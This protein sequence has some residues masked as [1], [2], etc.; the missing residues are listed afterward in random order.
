MTKQL[1]SEKV[2]LASGLHGQKETLI[3]LVS[4]EL[5]K[6]VVPYDRIPERMSDREH[7][8][9]LL[10]TVKKEVPAAIARELIRISNG[11]DTNLQALAL[12][13]ASVLTYKYVGADYFLLGVPASVIPVQ[14]SSN[15]SFK[16]LLLVTRKRL[17]EAQAYLQYPLEVLADELS[18]A[19]E[20][21]DNPFFDIAVMVASS[22]D[23]LWMNDIGTAFTFSLDIEV[24]L[25]QLTLYY[26]AE[27]YNQSSAERLLTHFLLILGKSL[28]DPEQPIGSISIMRD[29][30]I[31]QLQQELT[32]ELI[33]EGDVLLHEMFARK[34][35]DIPDHTAL[36][37]GECKLSYGELKKRADCIGRELLM[38]GAGIGT[39]AAIR[40]ERSFDMVAGILAILSIGGTYLPIEP[41][42]PEARYHYILEDSSASILL[43]SQNLEN[44]NHPLVKT[45][46]FVENITENSQ[47]DADDGEPDIRPIKQTL[48]N[49]AYI[50]YTS[51]TTGNPKGTVIQHKQI[52]CLLR[53][54]LPMFE[55]NSDDRWTLFHSFSFDFSVWEMFGALVTG[56]TLVI[57]A[58]HTAKDTTSFA[59][60]LIEEAVTV[61][62]QTPSAF[63]QLIR[64][65]SI[66]AWDPRYIIFGGEALMPSKIK[67]WAQQHVSVQ[68][69]NMYG[70][71]ETTIHATFKRLEEKD[72]RSSLSNIGVLLPHLQG[73]IVDRDGHPVPSGV[74]GEL[75][76]AGQGVAQG[77]HR[78]EKLTQ[79]RFM[80]HPL[81]ETTRFYRTGDLVRRMENGDLEYLGRMDQQVKIRGYRIEIGEIME[82]LLLHDSVIDAAITTEIDD[83]GRTEL[84]AYIIA[85]NVITNEEIRSF[86]EA[87]LPIYMVP[88]H[89]YETNS[90]P[91][92]INGKLDY[93]KLQSERK[94]LAARTTKIS[95]RN[96]MEQVIFD[97][98]KKHVPQK[99][100]F[101]VDDSLFYIG[102]HSLIASLII[103]EVNQYY[104]CTLSIRS[105]FEHPT[106][107]S[108][109]EEIKERMDHT[110]TNIPEIGNK[111]HYECSS[112]QER[113]YFLSQAAGEESTLYN[114]P[115]MLE[116]KG[117]LEEEK[118]QS[119][120]K[121]LVSR[122]AVLRTCLEVREG[123]PVMRIV[124]DHEFT[125]NT[126]FA[127]TSLDEMSLGGFIKSFVRPFK[128]NNV[129]LYRVELL[130]IAELHY[131][132][133][134]DMHHIIGDGTTLEILLSDLLS[135]YE[136]K[137]LDPISVGYKD[138]A[139]WQ[140]RGLGNKEMLTHEAYWLEQFGGDIPIL[141]LP[142]DSPKK[143]TDDW[144]GS[145]LK[146]TCDPDIVPAITAFAQNKQTTLFTV[147][148]AAF[149]V[150][151]HKYSGQN[152]IVVG[153]PVEGREHPDVK[154]VAGVFVNT[155]ALRN[156][157]S[158]QMTFDQ[159]L[160]EV[161][162]TLISALEHQSYPFEKLVSET[163]T[164]RGIN[165]NPLFDT[166][167]S[168]Q[169]SPDIPKIGPLHI[170]AKA[171]SPNLAKFDL[172]L[173]AVMHNERSLD[174]VWE[175]R[176]N[177]FREE[178]I[179]RLSE[180]FIQLLRLITDDPSVPL[181]EIS[182]MSDAERTKLL[183]KWNNT[184]SAYHASGG[185][186]QWFEKWSN[187][188]GEHTALVTSEERL[189]YDEL[190]K[191]S[192]HMAHLLRSYGVNRNTLVG[193][194]IRRN[195]NLLIAIMAVLKAG[196]AYLPIDPSFPGERIQHMLKNSGAK[197]VLT[198]LSK[199]DHITSAW[200]YDGEILRLQDE[201]AKQPASFANPQSVNDPDDMAYILYTSGST[202]SP[203]GVVITHD[204]LF[205]FIHA[206]GERLDCPA[207][208]GVLALTTVSFD[209]F[210]VEML[211]P[212]FNGM[213]VLL[214]DEAMQQDPEWLGKFVQNTPVHTL[215]LTP[216]RLGML[217]KHEAG[218]QLLSQSKQILVGG[219]HLSLVL[220]AELQAVTQA[221]I[222]NMYGPTETT[223]WST[224]QELTLSTRNDIGKPVANTQ[225]YVL[226]SLGKPVPT[227]V[228]GE[229]Y[230][231]GRGVSRG[232]HRNA[233]L[234]EE[235]FVPNIF[236]G[237]G[238]MYKT[239]DLVRWLEN[240]NL[241]YMGRLDHQVKIRGYRIDTEEVQE[242]IM[243]Y[244]GVA[245]A[246]VLTEPSQEHGEILVGYYTARDFCAPRE[247]RKHLSKF[248]PPYMVPGRLIHVSSFPL[249]PN[250]KLDRKRLST[251][252][253]IEYREEEA[254]QLVKPS[255]ELEQQIASIWEKVLGLSAPPSISQSFFEI[256]GNS[257]QASSILLI[258]NDRLGTNISLREFFIEPTVRALSAL[259]ET[260]GLAKVLTIPVTEGTEYYPLSPA[261]RRM[262]FLYQLE[263]E[264]QGVSYN[265]PLMVRVRGSLDPV[266][267][268]LALEKLVARHSSLRTYF[269]ILDGKPVQKIQPTAEIPVCYR[270]IQSDKELPE[271]AAQFIQPFTLEQAPLAR[272]CL[273]RIGQN[274]SQFMMDMH[275]IVADGISTDIIIR[276][277]LA[278]YEEKQLV[279]APRVDYKDYSVWQIH[280]IEAGAYQDAESFWLKLLDGEL[281]LL[282]LPIDRTR[283][284]VKGYD[285]DTIRTSL[286]PSLREK[287][288]QVAANK[289]VTLNTLLLTAYYTL[290]HRLT[291]QE[292]VIVG[293]PFANRQQ[294]DVQEMI[295]MFVNTVALRSYPS[296]EKTI[297]EYAG[298][299]S[300]LLLAAQEQQMI[301]FENLIERLN[302]PRDMSRNPLFDTMFSY[303]N[304]QQQLPVATELELEPY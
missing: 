171:I 17:N 254:H 270:E 46:I 51:G 244:E 25:V 77:Y 19:W 194:V 207:G 290:L 2:L 115:A 215:Q 29:E 99:A 216:S 223:I 136:E 278:L 284:A 9:T 228:P 127:I 188:L 237:D 85:R 219:E 198:D 283:P 153:T 138:Y 37:Y 292:D 120:F 255:T 251:T 177:L 52:T 101:G 73:M 190:N 44:I 195:P 60:L 47:V 102:G 247:V 157:P 137:T 28:S 45:V 210:F 119:A 75:W 49:P 57:V 5:P 118:L 81:M 220:L 230:I 212:L 144:Q 12:A 159:F 204:N 126:N 113:I 108:L 135:L 53:H 211:L 257:L 163:K 192:N 140:K 1:Y 285:G 55:F 259:V 272:V 90:M 208:A 30:E 100:D 189:T 107:A 67:D 24:D 280:Q 125:L 236:T 214:A 221:K 276:D 160:K 97:I 98:W 291:N 180:H 26:D 176:A 141:S 151:L 179:Q 174:L 266:R 150:L 169:I 35:I 271:V 199:E 269:E 72:F 238:R 111:Q 156:K 34:A 91:L 264:G 256:G 103:N 148:L 296:A 184:K 16:E 27:R 258:M 281:P 145:V 110:F 4:E 218:V 181:Q 246:A 263:G 297:R 265:M 205:N 78:K 143:N 225:V 250:G 114:M 146:S 253:A 152:D 41:S 106:I 56:G 162:Q 217:L 301:P 232:Y 61:L 167:F 294:A 68:L 21:T 158:G 260:K 248:L 69:V 96:E 193:I 161:H 71:T 62:N 245:E 182:W 40:L 164:E 241:M 88:A 86:L 154:K 92:T 11:S 178:T 8:S 274:D 261:Q 168:L 122:H 65:E 133:L 262:Y 139:A 213:N 109:C 147:L 94:K 175:Y 13:C 130:C 66:S 149:N 39:I 36:I 231:G 33:D 300:E 22:H 286:L 277:F 38:T 23:V 235:R 202:G 20:G 155:L 128:L 121:K 131:Y 267:M 112:A 132:L 3:G 239:G 298:E 288:I 196:G 124:P 63:Y 234:T 200:Q 166:W 105:I 279:P 79:E 203:K 59:R 287:L 222:F 172:S 80:F 289:G 273:V 224:V 242:A 275:H 249:T 295:G 240:G 142:L 93:R 229:L 226:D 299:V 48:N 43:T 187:I 76:I 206:M 58:E 185:I 123:H 183:R 10:H 282:N 89:I 64:E 54:T 32:T 303:Q 209:I 134:F 191:K 18:L 227:G 7:S 233:A 50:I 15:L 293:S 104:G 70:I 186:H 87:R 201:W 95:P 268:K 197:L 170:Q 74:P 117:P 6:P 14:I 42:L 82:K 129:P 173:Y 304:K 31:V 252:H 243:S 116:I 84:A 165:H 302:L 83:M